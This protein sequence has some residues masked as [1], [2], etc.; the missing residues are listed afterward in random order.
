MFDILFEIIVYIIVGCVL[1]AL[2]LLNGFLLVC[3]FKGVRAEASWF[4]FRVFSDEPAGNTTTDEE[5][6][7]DINVKINI[8]ED[9][10]V[11]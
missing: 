8:G 10:S 7:E 9:K 5:Q 2:I 4:P 6:K 11:K 1:L 3:L